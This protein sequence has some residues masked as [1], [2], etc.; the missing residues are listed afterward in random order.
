MEIRPRE[1]AGS[2]LVVGA[3]DCLRGRIQPFQAV[4]RSANAGRVRFAAP[5]RWHL[6]CE[7]EPLLC[8]TYHHPAYGH[9]IPPLAATKGWHLA[10]VQFPRHSAIAHEA[11]CPEFLN[12]GCQ[13][14]CA[15]VG[16]NHVRQRT[17]RFT[18]P[19]RTRM[20]S[21]ESLLAAQGFLIAGSG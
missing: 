11:R 20:A 17:R 2:A 14:P 1:W 21:A 7:S 8:Q 3:D 5:C 10:S 15:Q 9:R 6:K 13:C 16:G 12:H 4:Q 18:P 19:A